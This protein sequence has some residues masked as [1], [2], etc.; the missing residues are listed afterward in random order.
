MTYSEEFDK[1]KNIKTI[2]FDEITGIVAKQFSV[3]YSKNYKYWK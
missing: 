2:R 3:S 1:L